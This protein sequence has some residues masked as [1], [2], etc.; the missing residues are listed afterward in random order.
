MDDTVWFSRH[1]PA[2]APLCPSPKT[3]GTYKTPTM[4]RLRKRCNERCYYCGGQ[5]GFRSATIDHIYPRSKG[6]QSD[7][8]NLA[9][10]CEP[11]NQLKGDR[12]V[13]EFRTMVAQ[14]FFDGQYTGWVRRVGFNCFGLRF[15][16]P[17]RVIFYFEERRL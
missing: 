1:M 13:E 7:Y 11:C 4:K 17:P 9:L 10:A 15:T 16:T 6:G 8:H 14:F 2:V 3:R 5:L 12:T